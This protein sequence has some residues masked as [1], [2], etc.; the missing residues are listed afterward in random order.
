MQR[1]AVL[2]LWD[3]LNRRHDTL[4]RLVFHSGTTQR[5][6]RQLDALMA[7]FDR[8]MVKSKRI[9]PFAK[10]IFGE[11]FKLEK[12]PKPPLTAGKD[13]SPGEELQA[14]TTLEAAQLKA[15]VDRDK[16]DAQERVKKIAP[17]PGA[18][19]ASSA[20][21]SRKPRKPVETFREKRRKQEESSS[22]SAL[23]S[24]DDDESEEEEKKKKPS[25]KRKRSEG[26]AD[27]GK[28]KKRSRKGGSD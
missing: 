3:Q 21:S 20:G 1:K 4:A 7:F 23:S 24:E 8:G 28:A 22:S 27:K 14:E 2:K 9:D 10:E 25:R 11:D 18:S 19:A 5:T 17:K 6:A 26:D 12:D 16:A 13:L 15:D